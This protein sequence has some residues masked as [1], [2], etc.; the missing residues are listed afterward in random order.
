LQW[1]QNGFKNL[2]AVREAL[3]AL[4]LTVIGLQLVF[5]SFLLSILNITSKPVE[6]PTEVD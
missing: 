6:L 4:T 5:S 3:L 2:F 1:A